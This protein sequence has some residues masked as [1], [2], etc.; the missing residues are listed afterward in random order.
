MANNEVYR[1]G[2][3][4]PGPVPDAAA[5]DPEKGAGRALRLNGLNAVQVSTKNVDNTQYGNNLGEA[6]LDFGGAH[7]L[8]VTVTGGPVEF[9]DPIYITAANKLVTADAGDGSTP[10]FGHSLEYNVPN[11]ERKI[12]VRLAN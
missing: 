6:S 11:G 3:W 2:Q 1:I 7:K 12:T 4:V 8:P 10:I 5:N 9:G